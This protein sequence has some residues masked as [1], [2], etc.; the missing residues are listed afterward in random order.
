MLRPVWPCSS[1]QPHKQPRSREGCIGTHQIPASRVL[2]SLAS[3]AAIR[4]CH[5]TPRLR[6]AL[7]LLAALLSLH[8]GP[9]VSQFLLDLA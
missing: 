1:P 6:L 4:S 2:P 3:A 9:E 8:L 7:G 5:F